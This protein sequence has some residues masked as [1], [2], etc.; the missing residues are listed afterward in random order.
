MF[1][2]LFNTQKLP[3]LDYIKDALCILVGLSTEKF[4]PPDIT[5]VSHK[6][7]I[8]LKLVILF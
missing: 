5:L 6:G 7:K 1:H 4:E 8:T 3:S 2:P